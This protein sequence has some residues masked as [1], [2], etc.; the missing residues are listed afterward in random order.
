MKKSKLFLA[1]ALCAASINLFAQEEA[2]KPEVEFNPHFFIQLQGGAEETVGETSFLKLISPNAQLGIGYQFTPVWAL[3]LSAQG[4]ES[5]GAVHGTDVYDWNFVA[6]QLDVLVNLT[7]I[8]GF[9][10]RICDVNLIAGAAANI[11]FNNG[12]WKYKNEPIMEYYWA[13]TQVLPVGRVGLGVDFRL[14]DYVGLGLEATTNMLSDKYN[15]KKA[16]NIDWYFNALVGLKFYI[17][18]SYKEKEVV[19]E[20]KLPTKDE[21]ALAEAQAA[22]EK[23]QKERDA[24]IEEAKAARAAAAAAAAAPVEKKIEIFYP[25]RGS[26]IK[27]VE[28]E[29]LQSMIDFLK[30]HKDAKVDVR[31]YADKN[32]GNPTINLKYSQLRAEAVAKIMEQAGISADR[33]TVTALGDT[34]Q[35]FVENDKNRVTIAV[36]K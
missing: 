5:K 6:P 34:V 29:K 36:A 1:V 23:A 21:L 19:V 17:G 16:G 11:G 18:K 9:K 32:T 24:A 30:E 35:P 7:N 25:I 4:W 31:S 3:R 27:G 15:S 20:D 12:A 22:A 28:A 26:E 14:H 10:K 33:I 2:A 13:G 8:A